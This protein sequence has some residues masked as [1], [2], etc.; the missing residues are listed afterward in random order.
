[1]LAC[2]ALPGPIRISWHLHIAFTAKWIYNE[3]SA[4]ITLCFHVDPTFTVFAE[5]NVPDA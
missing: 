2:E 4:E 1:M 3:N 5:I